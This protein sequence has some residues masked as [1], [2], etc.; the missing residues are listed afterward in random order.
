MNQVCLSP[1]RLRHVVEDI[2]AR[3]EQWAGLVRYGTSERWYHRL[4]QDHDQEVWLL[5]WLPGQDTGFHDHGESAG[6]F[7]VAFGALCERSL[8]AGARE[9][10]G[11]TMMQG[12]VRSFGPGHIHAVSNASQQLAVS[13]HAYSPPLT[14][15]QRFELTGT[16]LVPVTVDTAD[17]W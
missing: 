4:T 8:S 15:M 12:T 3:P 11:I 10:V 14:T 13:I 16:G 1:A 9:P 5:S 7:A 6:A 2:A 17:Q